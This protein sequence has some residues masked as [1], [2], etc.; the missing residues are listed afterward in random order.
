M[1]SHLSPRLSIYPRDIN[2]P[3]SIILNLKAMEEYMVVRMYNAEIIYRG[4]KDTC[5]T[6]V[7]KNNDTFIS[8]PSSRYDDYVE[9]LINH[10]ETQDNN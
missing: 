1:T 4:L 3:I 9:T 5:D 2:D 8:I 6:M 10:Q 7:G